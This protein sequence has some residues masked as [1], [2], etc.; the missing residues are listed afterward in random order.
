MDSYTQ[1]ARLAGDSNR[2]VERP[3][4]RHEGRAGHDTLAVDIENALADLLR[5]P[6]VVGVHNEL[7]HVYVSLPSSAGLAIE[8]FATRSN[9]RATQIS[10]RILR[11]TA[12]ETPSLAA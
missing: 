1:P 12:K 9:P 7:L 8:Y 6:E 11:I 2:S 4:V 10:V 5:Q 3:A